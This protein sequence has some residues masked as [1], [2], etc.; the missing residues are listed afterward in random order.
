MNVQQIRQKYGAQFVRFF[1]V[2]V[3]ATLVHWGCYVGVNRLF[4]L[5]EANQLALNA[6][7]AFGYLVSFVG[8]YIVSLKWT[9]KTSGSVKKSLGFAFSHA[10][11]AGMHFLLLNL[12]IAIGLGTAI[13]HLLTACTPQLVKLLPILAEPDTLLPLP[14][15]AIVVPVNFILVR[16]FLT[17]GDEK[18]LD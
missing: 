12:F 17:Q 18:K 1:V 10:I 16:F 13:V 3:G 9:F 15:F 2:G 5:T 11:N 14:V 7:Y 4:H 8:N 6:S